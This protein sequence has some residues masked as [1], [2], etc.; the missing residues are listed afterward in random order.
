VRVKKSY[1]TGTVEDVTILTGVLVIE[2]RRSAAPVHLMPLCAGL[3]P[4]LKPRRGSASQ[5]R[6]GDPP[7]A[8]FPKN[9]L[10]ESCRNPI[11][12]VLTE[13]VL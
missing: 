7:G 10:G 13:A 6:A 8:P 3:R 1:V 5:P 12:L 11:G 4:R 9:R 2:R